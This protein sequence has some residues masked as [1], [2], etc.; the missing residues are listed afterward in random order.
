MPTRREMLRLTPGLIVLTGAAL[1]G[2]VAY[3]PQG[4]Q[5]APYP[6]YGY[7][8]PPPA[9]WNPNMVW[10]QSPDVYVALGLNFPVFFDSGAYY[11]NYGGRWYSG[12]SYRGPWKYRP[13]PP[14]S[15][16]DF[17]QNQWGGYQDRAR[18]YYQTNPNWKHFKPT[19]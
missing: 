12:P 2:C 5:P 13:D 18:G 19:H 10:L 11:S 8:P 9:T 1:T 7:P 14:R 4:A 3:P 6:D 17:H 16:H 15:L